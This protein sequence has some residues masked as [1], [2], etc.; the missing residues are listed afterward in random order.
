MRRRRGRSTAEAE[1]KDYFSISVET[2][3]ELNAS[4]MK[5]F[6][7]IEAASSSNLLSYLQKNKLKRNPFKIKRK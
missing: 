6:N 3:E 5:R 4:K 1:S 2:L 7:T